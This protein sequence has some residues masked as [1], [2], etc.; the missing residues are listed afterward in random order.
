MKALRDAIGKHVTLETSMRVHM[1]VCVT[2]SSANAPSI[3][4]KT[5]DTGIQ[6]ISI[7]VPHGTSTS[8]AI[9]SE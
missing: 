7:G 3:T 4:K 8:K 6:D 9:K 2:L 1:P 5:I